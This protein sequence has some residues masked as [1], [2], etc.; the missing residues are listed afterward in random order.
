M[1]SSLRNGRTPVRRLLP[2]GLLVAADQDRPAEFVGPPHALTGRLFLRRTDERALMLTRCD[3][4]AATLGGTADLQGPAEARVARATVLRG[5]EAGE[6]SVRLSL[7]R[8]TP[9]GRYEIEIEIGGERVAAVATV[10][11]VASLDIRPT[12]FILDNAPKLVQEKTVVVRNRGNVPLRVTDIGG[13]PLDDERLDCRLLRGALK[14]W[15]AREE[16][17]VES[18]FV[19]VGRQA[20]KALERAGL[21]RVHVQ[22]APFVLAPGEIRTITLA[23]E[24]PS[25]LDRH[26][27]YTGTAPFQLADLVFVIVPAVVSTARPNG[28]S[29]P[30]T[31]ERPAD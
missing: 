23:I 11:D 17:S 21:L 9:P 15:T 6:V 22:G 8:H 12:S 29:E 20:H 1:A 5:R 27:R 24:V 13:V 18:Y 26:T 4:L 31:G 25:T 2:D 16:R 30:Q 10:M 3:A 7:D 14:E 19:E 28:V